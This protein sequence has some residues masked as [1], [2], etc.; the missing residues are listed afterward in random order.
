MA[1]SEVYVLLSC[2]MSVDGAIDDAS[3]KRLLLSDPADLDRVDAV[4]AGCDAILVGANTIRSDNPRLQVRSAERRR[5]RRDRGLPDSPIK[6]TVTGGGRLDPAAAFFTM[7]EADKLVYC[8]SPAVAATRARLGHVATV[9]D[10]GDPIDLPAVLA[11]L[12]DRGV[13]RLLVE[14]GSRTHT[15]FLAAGLA[16]ELHLVVAPFFVGD[17]A[18]PR[19]VHPGAFPHG[20]GH[21]MTLANVRRIGDLVL[22]DYRLDRCSS[23]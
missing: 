13:R 19:F 4:R 6:V 12:A 15:A 23:T 1:A 21:P 20:P 22:L 14:G 10:G 7:G 3:E 2:A 11:D 5:A 9:V 18:A 16:D 8:A 17:A